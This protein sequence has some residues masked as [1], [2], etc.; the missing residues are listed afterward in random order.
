MATYLRAHKQEPYV[1][2]SVATG[3]YIAVATLLCAS[4]LPSNLYFLGF[5]TASVWNLPWATGIFW[6]KRREWHA[7]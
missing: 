2:V 1:W 3:A 4:F 5:L 6:R 7:S